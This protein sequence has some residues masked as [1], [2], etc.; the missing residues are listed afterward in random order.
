[1]YRSN[2]YFTLLPTLKPQNPTF[3]NYIKFA[4]FQI[5]RLPNRKMFGHA[6]EPQCYFSNLIS[7]ES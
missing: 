2:V 7:Y 1:M 6:F 5:L 3:L 4:H